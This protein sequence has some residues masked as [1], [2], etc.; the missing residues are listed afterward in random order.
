MKYFSIKYFL[1]YKA[2]K[3]PP[4]SALLKV[5]VPCGGYLVGFNLV[6]RCVYTCVRTYI[7]KEKGSQRE[8][9]KT[10]LL[11]YLIS[12]R[13]PRF[14]PRHLPYA[15]ILLPKNDSKTSEEGGN[16]QRSIQHPIM[17]SES[18]STFYLYVCRNLWTSFW[19]VSI[20]LLSSSLCSKLLRTEKLKS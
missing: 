17:Y 1:S 2:W 18:L 7:E 14:L 13:F 4:A 9:E 8:G 5:S 20:L 6:C 11:W 12:L 19:V 16:L 15:K 10:M 3:I